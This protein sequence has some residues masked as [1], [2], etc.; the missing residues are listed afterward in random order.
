MSNIWI[1]GFVSFFTDLGT[2]MVYPLVPLYL[3]SVG[4]TPLVI[5]MIEGVAESLTSLLQFV[6]GYTSDRLKRRKS[7]AIFGY[8]LSA[9]GRGILVFS[10]SWVGVFVWRLSDRVG[11]GV[12]TAP[13]DALIA[14]S[15]GRKRHGRA[16]GLHQMMDMTGAALGVAVAYL[17][18][19][20]ENSSYSTVF[21]YSL[22]PVA[23]GVLI[24][25]L[26]REPK[27]PTGVLKPKMEFKWSRLD[28]R[29]KQLLLVILLFTLANSSNQFLI[30]RASNLGVSMTDALLLYLLFHLT[31]ALFAYPMGRLSDRIGRKGILTA[32]YLLY[33][34]VYLGFALID[35]AKWVGVL[36]ALYGAYSGLTKG[37]EKALVADVAPADL[38]ATMMGMYAMFVAIGLL[39]ASLFAGWLWDSFGASAPFYFN[40]ALAVATAFLL[41]LALKNFKS[42]GQETVVGS[43]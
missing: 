34:G 35:S 42:V 3:V 6:S 38:K 36:F 32:G 29:L 13:R 16:F 30:L 2:Y 11:K 40:G 18:L 23:L 4:T 21:A 25:L 14:E 26:V 15:G 8:G 43:E 39:P 10:A 17:I 37:V 9:A 1:L 24:L 41:R 12:R 19:Q 33:G 7:L 28:P 20:Q 22:I 27:E 31:G 5:G